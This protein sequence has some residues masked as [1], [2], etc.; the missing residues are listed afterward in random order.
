MISCCDMGC[1]ILCG[2]GM[3]C[4]V[5]CCKCCNGDGCWEAVSWVSNSSLVEG[6]A[7]GRVGFVRGAVCSGAWCEVPPM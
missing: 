4:C 2:D 7:S 1:C 5:G 6:G 3:D